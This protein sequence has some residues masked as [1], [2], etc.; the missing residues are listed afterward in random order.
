MIPVM[1][2]TRHLW[3]FVVGEFRPTAHM[4]RRPLCFAAYTIYFRQWQASHDMGLIQSC[5]QHVSLAD[6]VVRTRYLKRP[7]GTRVPRQ[8]SFAAVLVAHRRFP[9]GRCCVALF[10][11]G[12]LEQQ[13]ALVRRWRKCHSLCLPFFKCYFTLP[14]SKHHSA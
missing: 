13:G 3:K 10:I 1:L 6:F 12:L 4:I 9:E 5:F 8:R 11:F 2:R 7:W 14:N